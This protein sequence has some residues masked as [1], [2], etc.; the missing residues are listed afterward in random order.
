MNAVLRISKILYNYITLRSTV[1]AL[2]FLFKN[3]N[4][5]LVYKIEFYF[6]YSI[7]IAMSNCNNDNFLRDSFVISLFGIGQHKLY[8]I[9][10]IICHG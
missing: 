1:E 3:F 6:T 2:Q 8:T 4:A 10:G 5:T 7:C 9:R